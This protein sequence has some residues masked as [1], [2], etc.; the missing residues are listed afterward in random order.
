[1]TPGGSRERGLGLSGRR[2]RGRRTR[3]YDWSTEGLDTKD[4]KDTKALL[5]E[6]T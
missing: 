6:L 5:A 3:V 4:L 1:M 2:G